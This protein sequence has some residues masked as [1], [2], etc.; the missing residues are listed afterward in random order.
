MPTPK[1]TAVTKAFIDK[2]PWSAAFIT[3][4]MN[5]AGVN[6]PFSGRSAAHTGYAQD[7][8]M[9][10]GNYGFKVIDPSTIGSIGFLP[11][12]IVIQNGSGTNEFRDREPWSGAGTHGD[13]VVRRRPVGDMRSG[14]D[15]T[16]AA[17]SPGSAP[18]DRVGDTSTELIGGNMSDTVK[19]RP[20][21]EDIFGTKSPKY[22][23]VLRPP[24]E[25]VSKI[26][27]VVEIEY[28][29][30]NGVAA[31]GGP[32]LVVNEDYDAA[33]PLL[34][35]YYIVVGKKIDGYD[36]KGDSIYPYPI[37]RASEYVENTYVK[38][39][40]MGVMDKLSSG[41]PVN[42][43][44][45]QTAE[46]GGVPVPESAPEPALTYLTDF[47]NRLK[48]PATAV[49]SKEQLTGEL[50]L[51]TPI[52]DMMNQFT[53]LTNSILSRT[54]GLIP[55]E[56]YFLVEMSLFEFFPDRMRTELAGNPEMPTGTEN[57][58]SHA[59]RAPG[60]LA[61]TIDLT[62]PGIAGFTVGQ[63]FWVDRIY[64]MYKQMGVF[65]MFSFSDSITVDRGWTTSLHARLNIM[66]KGVMINYL[67]KQK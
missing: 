36:V 59:W 66:P 11:G 64:D 54:V 10:K 29:K 32:K 44:A 16:I 20:V 55:S 18:L 1:Q 42:V 49:I 63:V 51:L 23:V 9:A 6:F 41:V 2:N 45:M 46:I 65:Q 43:R 67:N 28:N 57:T 27:E 35:N 17:S 14:G 37:L 30:W 61:T 13:I 12:D 5:K 52:T 3:Y 58:N 40:G 60:K 47:E 33:L 53:A 56:Q 7:I 4:V 26:L 22:F 31:G 38:P 21:T 62:I 8:R 34:Q 50:A 25:F 39:L 48:E 15:P 24:Q 19:R